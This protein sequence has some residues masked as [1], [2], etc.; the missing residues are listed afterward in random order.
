MGFI[1]LLQGSQEKCFF[2]WVVKA[3]KMGIKLGSVLESRELALS[4]IRAPLPP[5]L[6]K[7]LLGVGKCL[8]VEGREEVETCKQMHARMSTQRK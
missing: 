5:F 7:P 6:I 1:S 8:C 4:L 2:L 3:R